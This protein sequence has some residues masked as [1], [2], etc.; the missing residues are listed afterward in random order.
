MKLSIQRWAE[1]N[2]EKSLI[3]ERSLNQVKTRKRINWKKHEKLEP[4]VWNDWEQFAQKIIKERS[5]STWK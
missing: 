2:Q 3:A 4:K 1:S 5:T